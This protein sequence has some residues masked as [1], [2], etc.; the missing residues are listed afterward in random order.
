ML[1]ISDLGPLNTLT[2]VLAG[3]ATAVASG[4][5]DS[6]RLNFH[7]VGSRLGQF[8]GDLHAPHRVIFDREPN[9]S[10]VAA[11]RNVE[12]EWAVKPIER[13]LQK[14]DIPDAK[15]LYDRIVEDFQPTDSSAEEPSFVLGDLT[16]GAIL[17]D[18]LSDSEEST[19]LGVI[20]WEFSGRGRGMHGDM[21]Q[22]L[23]QVHLH[24][25]AAK[26]HSRQGATS[27]IEA[28]ID[29]ITTAYRTQRRET[30]PTWGTSQISL[31]DHHSS[32]PPPVQGT[33]AVAATAATRMLRS[34]FILHGR[35]MINGAF[36]LDWHCEYCCCCR[37]EPENKEKC[38]L[39]KTM[40]DR[41]VWYLRTATASDVE[42][43][44]PDNWKT[45]GE[46][47]GRVLINMLWEF[48]DADR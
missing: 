1:V 14:C 13:H 46:E 43:V 32:T 33:Q 23:A 9:P 48:K 15:E 24:L 10:D 5:I 36:D 22:L 21:A 7:R 29:G 40:V 42:F 19:R 27:A 6:L 12:L 25:I 38:A 11:K 8:L 20:D 30:D 28:F 41:G 39:I 26:E 47:E 18:D 4:L 17:L 35:E 44:Q 37:A 45:V 34:A 2:S 3:L 31:D 16:P